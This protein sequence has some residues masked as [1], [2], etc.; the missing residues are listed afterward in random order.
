MDGRWWLAAAAGK[1]LPQACD[2]KDLVPYL[3]GDQQGD[4]HEYIFWHNA[5][6]TDAPRRNLYAVRWQDWRLIKH[7]DGWHLYGLKN[8]PQETA[9]LAGSQSAVVAQMRSRYDEF[10]A[11]IPPVKPSAD[12]KGGGQV[13]NG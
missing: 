1:A 5:D 6:P 3:K 13:P 7:P 8:D 11:T 10:V 12:Y 4:V 2:G 9:D